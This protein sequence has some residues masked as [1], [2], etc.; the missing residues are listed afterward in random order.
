MTNSSTDA[1][2][3][4]RTSTATLSSSSTAVLSAS[5]TVE[6]L[7]GE[8]FIGVV[9]DVDANSHS[10]DF[11]AWVNK[12]GSYGFGSKGLRASARGYT[13]FGTAWSVGDT[14]DVTVDSAGNMYIS[15]NRGAQALMFA[16]V[17]TGPHLA[18]AV[19]SAAAGTS[20]RLGWGSAAASC[21]TVLSQ[22]A[23]TNV[24]FVISTRYPGGEVS[25]TTLG[26][27]QPRAQG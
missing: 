11:D 9:T 21:A 10:A 26:R 5:F 2:V 8:T 24:P 22:S 27:T 15:H 6:A 12:N 17:A 13:S 18:A 3:A 7:E 19:W 14:V 16:G 4:G 25:V 23:Q 1:A 20:I